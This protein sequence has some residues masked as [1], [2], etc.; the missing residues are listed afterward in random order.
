MPNLNGIEATQLIRK[1]KKYDK[2]KIIGN[3][4]SLS[5]FTKEELKEIGF[6]AFLT[7][8]YKVTEFIKNISI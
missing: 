7:K 6:D 5:T 4:A 8:P 2:I 3:T 1:N